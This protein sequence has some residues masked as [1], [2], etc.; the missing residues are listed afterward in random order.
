[1]S[2]EVSL[3]AVALAGGKAIC[4][5]AGMTEPIIKATIRRFIVLPILANVSDASSNTRRTEN[6]LFF[7]P[8]TDVVAVT[9]EKSGSR[10]RAN[11]P[12]IAKNAMNWAPRVVVG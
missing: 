12:L 5:L 10:L 7:A 1:L 11:I 2:M 8:I 6:L 9:Q 4:A 3:N